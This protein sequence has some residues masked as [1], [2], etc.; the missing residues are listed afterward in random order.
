MTESLIRNWYHM[1]T[2]RSLLTNSAAM[3]VASFVLPPAVVAKLSA[4][5]AASLNSDA[6]VRAFNAMG[7]K[8]GSGTP[9]AMAAQIE[10]DMDVFTRVIRERQLKFES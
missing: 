2:R 5:L 6:S 4:A 1:T 9:D 8:P 10:R 7:F 3:L